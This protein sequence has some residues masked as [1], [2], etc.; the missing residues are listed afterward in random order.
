MPLPQL[1]LEI[2]LVPQ[3]CFGS[4]LRNRMPQRQWGKL[5]KEI[6]AKAGSVCNVCGSDGK[7][8]CHEKWQYDDKAHVQK[9]IGFGVLCAMCH[10]VCHFGRTAEIAAK[11]H[12][13]LDD[14]ISHF[15][16]VNGVSREVF[17]EHVKSAYSVWRNRSMHQWQTDC[18]EWSHLVTKPVK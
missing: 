18:G 5:R 15:C 10:N 1:K 14:V 17:D 4:N 13:D 6:I 12:V 7:L 2:D 8:N 3:T 9:L 16:N 11:G